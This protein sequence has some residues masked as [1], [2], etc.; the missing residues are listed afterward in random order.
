M[1]DSDDRPGDEPKLSGEEWVE[2]GG[3]LIWAVDFTPGGAP[4]GLTEYETRTRRH[5]LI[6]LKAPGGLARPLITLATY[7]EVMARTSA[8]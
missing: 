2:Y 3:A 1:T 7:G 6:P 8:L 4:I 5:W